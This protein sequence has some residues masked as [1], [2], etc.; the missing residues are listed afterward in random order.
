MNPYDSQ[1]SQSREPWR[2]PADGTPIYDR[3]V[4]EWRAAGHE[5]P[6]SEGPY[7]EPG[8]RAAGGFVPAARTPGEPF[9]G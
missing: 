2:A 6:L 4:A 9:G 5:H 3:L 8:L 1:T 7:P